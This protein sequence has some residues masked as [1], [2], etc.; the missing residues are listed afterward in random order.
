MS[1]PNMS[2]VI[3]I[4]RTIA[5]TDPPGMNSLMLHGQSADGRTNQATNE[6]GP[7]QGEMSSVAVGV[8]ARS[9]AVS[10]TIPTVR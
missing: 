9:N 6:R 8:S 5:T 2:A 10:Q 3:P 1:A 7:A 4:S